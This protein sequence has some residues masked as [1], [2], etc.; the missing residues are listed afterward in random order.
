[1]REALAPLGV[2]VEVDAS[3]LEREG[4]V[5]LEWEN[6]PLHL[7]FSY[8]SLHEEMAQRIH[9]VPFDGSTLPLVAPSTW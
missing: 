7:F 3:E 5:K 4:Q 9:D 1:M 6:H 8:D 2:D